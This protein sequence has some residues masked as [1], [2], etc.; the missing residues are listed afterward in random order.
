MNNQ[1]YFSLSISIIGKVG[2]QRKSKRQGVKIPHDIPLSS[3]GGKYTEKSVFID[4][5]IN[6]FIRE[7]NVRLDHPVI[8]AQFTYSI[9]HE[10]GLTTMYPF[11]EL[12]HC[13]DLTLSPEVNL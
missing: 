3:N 7:N 9:D 13:F 4:T 6:N 5:V 11:N 10:N 2:S 1:P 8:R 12:S